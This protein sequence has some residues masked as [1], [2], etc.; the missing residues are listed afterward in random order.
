MYVK[1]ISIQIHHSLF[2]FFVLIVRIRLE[3]VWGIS[4]VWLTELLDVL[5]LEQ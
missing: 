2:R 4:W 1:K 3:F 5:S